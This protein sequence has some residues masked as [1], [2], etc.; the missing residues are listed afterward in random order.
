MPWDFKDVVRISVNSL[1]MSAFLDLGKEPIVV[2]VPDSGAISVAAR[3]LNM[4]TDDFGTPGS[5]TP[6]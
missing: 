4:W 6:E 5:R 1:W 2:S 3:W